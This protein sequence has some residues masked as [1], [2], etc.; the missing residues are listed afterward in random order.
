[1]HDR[2]VFHFFF[3]F[4]LKGTE[5]TPGLAAQESKV[6]RKTHPA[7]LILKIKGFADGA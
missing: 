1:M 3:F 4:L 5:V 7:L 2:T 6:E